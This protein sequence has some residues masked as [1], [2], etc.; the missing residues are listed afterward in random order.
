MKTYDCHC[1]NDDCF[2][3]NQLKAEGMTCA[4]C[5]DGNH[6]YAYSVPEPPTYQ[7]LARLERAIADVC[8]EDTQN[9]I[10][11]RYRALEQENGRAQAEGTTNG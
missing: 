5:I 4:G 11:D 7:V 10:A 1:K 8:D 3:A 2:C 6:T 9:A